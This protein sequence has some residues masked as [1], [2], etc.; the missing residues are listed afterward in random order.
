MTLI[1]IWNMWKMKNEIYFCQLI[2]SGSQVIWKRIECF[3]C[4]IPKLVCGVREEGNG[5]S[6]NRMAMKTRRI[7]V[8]MIGP[9]TLEARGEHKS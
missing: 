8:K 1:V 4:A 7:T 6:P 3:L 9:G 5:I 2:W